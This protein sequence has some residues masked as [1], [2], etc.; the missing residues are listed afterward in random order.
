[1]AESAVVPFPHFRWPPTFDPDCGAGELV[2]PAQPA[3]PGGSFA[4]EAS[5]WVTAAHE[6]I[7]GHALQVSRLLEPDVSLACGSLGF[8]L[9]ALEGWAVYAGSELAPELP[10]AARFLTF[11]ND[12]RRA[13]VAFLDPA[14]HHG[15]LAVEQASRFLQTRVGLTERAA[16]QTFWRITVWWPGQAASYFYGHSQLAALRTAVECRLGTA[17]DRQHFHNTVLGQGLLP[18]SLLRRSVLERVAPTRQRAA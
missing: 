15:Q 3:D 2:L 10:L 11:H 1:M 6:G 8:D 16:R 7:P 18:L 13:A 14:L 12:L 9:A 17:F 5:S 4:T